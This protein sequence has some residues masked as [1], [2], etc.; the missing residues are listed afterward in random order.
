MPRLAAATDLFEGS[1][2]V[3]GQAWIFIP[4][5]QRRNAS[6]TPLYGAP[7]NP[8]ICITQGPAPDSAVV[9]R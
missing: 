6:A 5:T 2:P 9:A 7:L 4:S 1:I 3:S 8:T